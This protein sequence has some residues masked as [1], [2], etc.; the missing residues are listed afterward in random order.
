MVSKVPLDGG[1]G[2]AVSGENLETVFMDIVCVHVCVR[3]CVHVYISVCACLPVS[4]AYIFVCALMHVLPLHG[5]YLEFTQ[6]KLPEKK[7]NCFTL[8]VSIISVRSRK[9]KKQTQL[10]P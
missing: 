5:T 2:K 9:K 8:L 7:R 4:C 1:Q 3:M 10:L 6:T